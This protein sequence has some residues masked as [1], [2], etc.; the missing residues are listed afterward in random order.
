MEK[1]VSWFLEAF[2]DQ[3]SVLSKAC[4][5]NSFNPELNCEVCFTEHGSGCFD[6]GSV[7]LFSDTIYLRSLDGREV[8]RN[9]FVLEEFIKSIVFE[10]RTMITSD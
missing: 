8:L 7:S 4:S 10:F 5:I 3:G 2:D 9:T 6:Y 1:F